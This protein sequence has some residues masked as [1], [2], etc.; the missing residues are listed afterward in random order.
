MR[1]ILIITPYDQ[2]TLNVFLDKLKE[3]IKELPIEVQSPALFADYIY[4]NMEETNPYSF[5]T[6]FLAAIDAY[7]NM[8]IT[9]TVFM[10]AAPLRF[11]VG[12]SVQDIQYDEIWL[13]NE[14]IT[15]THEGV[16]DYYNM[17][18]KGNIQN[19]LNLYKAEDATRKFTTFKGLVAAISK[20]LGKELRGYG[21]V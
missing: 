8:A 5:L 16:L 1:D 21:D 18:T 4:R 17:H 14:N 3:D 12:A 10:T 19:Y 6:C 11:M 7:R 20:E 13:Y 2:D 9:D 15:T